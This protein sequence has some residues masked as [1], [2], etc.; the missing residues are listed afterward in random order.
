MAN[1]YSA[2][3]EVNETEGMIP[4]LSTSY[5]FFFWYDIY[6]TWLSKEKEMK[7]F[8]WSINRALFIYS[9]HTTWMKDSA[10]LVL[11]FLF[12]WTYSRWKV[13]RKSELDALSL[14]QVVVVD[15]LALKNRRLRIPH[16]LRYAIEKSP[17]K[18]KNR[19]NRFQL[20][21]STTQ[22]EKNSYSGK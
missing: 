18:R 1:D 11:V 3:K 22:L 6:M 8:C 14:P 20:A 15:S 2:I 10:S 21:N 12:D 13:K 16:L 7:I 19:I 4:H 17:Y 5:F 9:T